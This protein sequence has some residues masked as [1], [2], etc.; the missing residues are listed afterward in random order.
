MCQILLELSFDQISIKAKGGVLVRFVNFTMSMMRNSLKKISFS[1]YLPQLT[2]SSF[3]F[4]VDNGYRAIKVHNDKVQ[5]CKAGHICWADI[6][7]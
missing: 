1:N 5:Y 3:F 2:F 7:H 6:V 4:I